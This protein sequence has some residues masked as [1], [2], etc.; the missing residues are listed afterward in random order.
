MCF[1]TIGLALGASAATATT[2]GMMA[3]STAISAATAIAQYQA[4]QAAYKAQQ[5][6]FNQNKLLAQRSM[7]EQAR[8]VAMREE[9]E[10]YAASDKIMQSNIAAAK[11][12][13]R[14]VASTG[15][16]GVAGMSIS[17][18]L[19]DVE[20]T[21]L[22]NEGTINRNMEAIAQQGRVDREGLLTQAEGRINSVDQGTRPSLLATGLQIGGIALNNYMDYKKDTRNP[23]Y[24]SNLNSGQA[25]PSS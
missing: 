5:Q 14:L 23:V 15:E 17:A 22:N 6:Q 19:M 16:A 20:R 8:Q 10:R 1:A 11:A 18:L 9:Q 25:N 2:A 7:L 13:G 12:K 24:A 4:Q 3:V 21:R